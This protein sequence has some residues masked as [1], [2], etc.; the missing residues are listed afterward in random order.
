MEELMLALVAWI[1]TG[2]CGDH[3]T[4]E[5]AEGGA[6]RLAYGNFL[7]MKNVQ[8]TPQEQ[9]NRQALTHWAALT[10]ARAEELRFIGMPAAAGSLDA[11]SA[12]MLGI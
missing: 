7:H 9:H 2:H 3:D 12:I 10:R 8:K 6:L 4:E 5:C 1:Q 11:V